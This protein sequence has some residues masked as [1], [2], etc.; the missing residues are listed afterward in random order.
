MV[1]FQLGS[2][3]DPALAISITFKIWVELSPSR[4]FVHWVR[5]HQH[6]KASCAASSTASAAVPNLAGRPMA[7]SSLRSAANQ[8]RGRGA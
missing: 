8:L 2:E 6:K 7:E 3:S 5:L 4:W 1:S